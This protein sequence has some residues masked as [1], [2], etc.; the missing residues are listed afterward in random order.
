[1]AQAIGETAGDAGGAAGDQV[2]G[3]GAAPKLVI[4]GV[5]STRLAVEVAS[6]ELTVEEA[7]TVI[8]GAGEE[9]GFELGGVPGFDQD[10]VVAGA[11]KELEDLDGEMVEPAGEAESEQGAV[12]DAAGL[13]GIADTAVDE[14]AGVIVGVGPVGDI[15]GIAA[16]LAVDFESIGDGVKPGREIGGGEVDEVGVVVAQEDKV[17]TG[18]SSDESGLGKGAF[19]RIGFLAVGAVD[20]EGIGA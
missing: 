7:D 5:A 15:E 14:P 16:T 19:E 4:E 10:E 18:T 3:D 8:A 13:E 17:I 2:G 12:A 1:M 20:M 6:D 11:E 9:V